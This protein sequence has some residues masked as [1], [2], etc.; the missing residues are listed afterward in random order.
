MEW[1]FHGFISLLGWLCK[2]TNACT[3][4][5]TSRAAHL[6][7]KMRSSPEKSGFFP[8]H[9][10]PPNSLWYTLPYYY[11]FFKRNK[12]ERKRKNVLTFEWSQSIFSLIDVFLIDEVRRAKTRRAAWDTSPWFGWSY[13]NIQGMY[14]LQFL[15][16]SVF[17]TINIFSFLASLLTRNPLA[18]LFNFWNHKNITCLLV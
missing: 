1:F 4:T 13:G 9:K 3:C 17:C 2:C 10:F 15:F 11:Y 5:C 7:C 14:Y 8:H 6:W 12:N 18:R 16:S